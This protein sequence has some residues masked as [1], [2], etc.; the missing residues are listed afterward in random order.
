LTLNVRDY[1]LVDIYAREQVKTYSQRPDEYLKKSFGEPDMLENARHGGCQQVQV[2]LGIGEEGYVERS[3][4][5]TDSELKMGLA[6]DLS[7]LRST[8]QI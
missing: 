6:C 8:C 4:N 5:E 2:K 7:H 1:G 3:K